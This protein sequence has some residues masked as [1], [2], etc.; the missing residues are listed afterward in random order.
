MCTNANYCE[1]IHRCL[2]IILL[3]AMP[4]MKAFSYVIL[5]VSIGK[6][7]AASEGYVEHDL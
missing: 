6:L 7:S 4:E 5:A 2:Q 1:T 3:R